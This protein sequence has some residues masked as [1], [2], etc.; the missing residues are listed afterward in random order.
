MST[1]ARVARMVVG[2]SRDR[3]F[4]L[5]EL[6]IAISLLALLSAVL[7]GSLSF[8]GRS[9]D[10]GEAKVE[11]TANMRL[12]S[13]YLRTQ[14]SSQHPQRMRKLLEFPLLFGGERDEIRYAAPLPAR[15]GLGGMWYYRLL[16]IPNAEKNSSSLVLE[17]VIPDLDATAIPTFSGA[18]HSVLADGIKDLKITYF[19]RD[20]A[21][22]PEMTPTWRDRWD[23]P[24]RLPLLLRLEV[25][26]RLGQPWPAVVIA[27]RSAP[28]AG[29]RG[30]DTLRQQCLGV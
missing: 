14:L 19:G 16:L 20:R 18:E 13:D 27:P 21:A 4:T 25:T 22:S 12:A 24:Q 5:V 23:D 9:W 26:P 17:R 7:F 10:A 3:G 1:A 30:W 6:L 11:A 8:A 15:I 28:E 29:C 2:P